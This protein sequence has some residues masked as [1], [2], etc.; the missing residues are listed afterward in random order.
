MWQYPV[1]VPGQ[2]VRRVALQNCPAADSQQHIYA[3]IGNSLLALA[4][5]G[6]EVKVLWE[7]PLADHVPGS[8]VLGTDCQIRVHAG[9]GQLYC[10]DMEGQ[11]VWSPVAVGQPLGWASP[12]VDGDG[13]T[14]LCRYTGGLMKVDP[15]GTPQPRPFFRSRQK[16][17]STG[18]IHQGIFYVGAEDGFVYAIRLDGRKGTNVWNHLADQGK[19]DWFINSSPALADDSTLI[20]AGRDE[21]LYAFGLDGSRRG[22]VH[23]RGQMLGSPV[24][25]PSGEIYVGVSIAKLGQQ[26]RGKLVA[27]SGEAKSVRWEYRAQGA[28]ES[29]PVIG[30]DGIIYFGDNA[31]WIHAVDRNGKRRWVQ[32]VGSPVRS[33]GTLYGPNRLLFGL[34]DGTLVA[35]RCSSDSVATAGWPKYMGTLSQSAHSS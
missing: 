18:L 5:V 27:A 7:Y 8:P 22:W 25:D 20:V 26:S 11:Q 16:F 15:R 1:H 35:L 34:D 10:V 31:G 17:D 21:Y 23:I 24:V 12:V 30:S 9:D 19:T 6:V 29:T 4:E 32:D 14:W 2:D 33:A 13:N 3:A 28:V